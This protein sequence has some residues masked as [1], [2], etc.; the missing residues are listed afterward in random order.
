MWDFLG[1]LKKSK[2][3]TPK[4]GMLQRVAMKKFEK[5]SPEER[6]KIERKAMEMMKPENIAKNKDQI[7]AT[8]EQM[9]ISGQITDEQIAEAKKRLGL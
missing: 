8:M 2:D 5:M 1:K 7:L 9:K 6:E 4:M 3:K